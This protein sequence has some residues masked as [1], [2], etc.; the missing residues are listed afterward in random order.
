MIAIPREH[1]PG[2]HAGAGRRRVCDRRDVVLRVVCHCDVVA[3]SAIEGRVGRFAAAEH[4][5]THLA[6]G[7]WRPDHAGLH[8]VERR[9]LIVRDALGE[10][11]VVGSA[12]RHDPRPIESARQGAF[13]HHVRIGQRQRRRSTEPAVLR[14]RSILHDEDRGQPIAVFRPE[15]AG[16]QFE[17]I[18]RLR[19]ERARKPE[20]AI[21]IV[22]LDVVHDGEVLIGSSPAYG[23]TAAES[24]VADTPGIVCRTRKTLST[25]PGTDRTSCGVRSPSAGPPRRPPLIRRRRRARAF[26]GRRGV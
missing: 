16:R 12:C 13:Q 18:D 10:Q 26:Q 7:P 23:Q 22:N 17:T 14:S 1:R 3:A 24:S 25:A 20:E 6:S 5:Q 4:R 8:V 2:R 19:I 15:P 9:Q 21:R 11:V